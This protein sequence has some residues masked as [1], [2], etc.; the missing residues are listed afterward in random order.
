MLSDTDQPF[1][2]EIEGFYETSH[3]AEKKVITKWFYRLDD[4]PQDLR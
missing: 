3:T 1:I 4:I 2:G